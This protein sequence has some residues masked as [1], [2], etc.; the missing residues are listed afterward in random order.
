MHP[1]QFIA[2]LVGPLLATIGI[3]LMVNP[4]VYR[5]L[6]E[7]FLAAYPFIYLSGIVLLVGGLTILN[8]HN[9]WTRDWRCLITLLGWLATIAGAFRIMAPQFFAYVGTGIFAHNGFPL[10]ASIV[11]LA[12]G[13]FLSFKGYAD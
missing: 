7:Q 9:V 11:L 12:L 1:A 13:G 8:V 3:G 10:G 2:R 5:K 4:G 6:F